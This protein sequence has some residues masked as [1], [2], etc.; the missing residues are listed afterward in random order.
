MSEDTPSLLDEMIE[1]C[2][3]VAEDHVIDCE[4]YNISAEHADQWN[5]ACEAIANAIRQL[6]G[7]P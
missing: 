4:D 1:R 7:S 6:K 2:A 3:R 5:E